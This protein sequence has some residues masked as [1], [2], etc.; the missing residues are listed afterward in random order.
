L[1]IEGCAPFYLATNGE[2]R[3]EPCIYIFRYEIVGWKK[4][5]VFRMFRDM[6]YQ[7][8]HQY[9][10]ICNLYNRTHQMRPRIASL[11]KSN[12]PHFWSLHSKVTNFFS[13]GK[14]YWVCVVVQSSVIHCHYI[15]IDAAILWMSL[16]REIQELC[17]SVW[18][19]LILTGA[20]L[21]FFVYNTN[22]CIFYWGR[23]NGCS[24]KF[25]NGT[26]SIVLLLWK[27]S[28]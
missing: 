23:N 4:I 22:I 25:L 1:Y 14:L 6:F 26:V 12:P 20:L 11:G 13:Y 9:E 16:S 19:L 21:P 2:G 28:I 24:K 15:V 3:R 27:V 10:W 17:F 8:R 18:K 5:V 7:S